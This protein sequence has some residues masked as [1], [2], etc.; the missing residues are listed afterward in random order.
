[1]VEGINVDEISSLISLVLS[2]IISRT[3]GI[4]AHE[5]N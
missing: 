5:E 1:M 3:F 4:L 2:I